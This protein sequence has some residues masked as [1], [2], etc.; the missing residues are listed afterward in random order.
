MDRLRITNELNGLTLEDLRDVN[1]NIE[2]RIRYKERE[3][4]RN[5][6][7]TREEIIKDFLHFGYGVYPDAKFWK[8]HGPS[9]KGGFGAYG[10]EVGHYTHSC[11]ID[12]T[13][14]YV[15]LVIDG[16]EHFVEGYSD[17]WLEGPV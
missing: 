12:T 16:D 8:I 5:R 9:T 11:P 15:L 1:D 10:M 17:M 14:L 3:E 13:K 6:V 4:K 2:E 7:K